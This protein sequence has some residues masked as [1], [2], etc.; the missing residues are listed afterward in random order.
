[1]R[2]ILLTTFNIHKLSFSECTKNADCNTVSDPDKKICLAGRCI[3]NINYL[4][5]IMKLLKS[6]F[7]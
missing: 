6:N 1:M 2:S 5:R 7:D 3:R 4:I